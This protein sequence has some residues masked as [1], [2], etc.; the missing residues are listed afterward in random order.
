MTKAYFSQAMANTL[1]GQGRQRAGA[2]AE[3]E[4]DRGASMPWPT[5][6]S[7]GPRLARPRFPVAT[8]VSPTQ[9]ASDMLH[10]RAVE[11]ASNQAGATTSCLGATPRRGMRMVQAGPAPSWQRLSL[12]LLRDTSGARATAAAPA[13]TERPYSPPVQDSGQAEVRPV[14]AAALGRPGDKAELPLFCL[15][16]E[17]AAPEAQPQGVE[18]FAEAKPVPT[19]KT[20]EE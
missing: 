5:P 15:D 14:S 1:P 10:A 12:S 18:G 2:E 20:W 3:D 6:V 9:M 19:Q 4:G 17:A 11:G 7:S 8:R 13:A 16:S